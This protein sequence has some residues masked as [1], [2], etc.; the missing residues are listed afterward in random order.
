MHR[1]GQCPLVTFQSDPKERQRDRELGK[2][3]KSKDPPPK[4]TAHFRK[5]EAVFLS[6]DGALKERRRYLQYIFYLY[7]L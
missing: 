2:M 1:G 6:G 7:F 4:K 3:V 5:D